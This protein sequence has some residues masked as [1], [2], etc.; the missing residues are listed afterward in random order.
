MRT[1]TTVVLLALSGC[2]GVIG[3]GDS[4]ILEKG[5]KYWVNPEA[6]KGL[7]HPLFLTL[8][9]SGGVQPNAELNKAYR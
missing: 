1:W 4:N 2:T 8:G 9:I 5:Q 7:G 6:A 3:L